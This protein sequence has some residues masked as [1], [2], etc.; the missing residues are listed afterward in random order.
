MSDE[1]NI[2]TPPA[3]YDWKQAPVRSFELRDPEYRIMARS[4]SKGAV[5]LPTLL[6][7][8]QVVEHE[9]VPWLMWADPK[10]VLYAHPD[11]P[12][13]SLVPPEGVHPRECSEAALWDLGLTDHV[14]P[15]AEFEKWV[16]VGRDKAAPYIMEIAGRSQANL[17]KFVLDYCDGQIY[18]DHHVP[19]GTDVGM[20]FMILALGAFSPQEPDEKSG[21]PGEPAWHAAQELPR[22]SPKPESQPKPDPPKR[23]TDPPRPPDAVL[24]TPDPE[25]E[26]RIADRFPGLDGVTDIADLLA[27]AE[28][29]PDAVFQYR[30][31]IERK[32]EERL[33]EHAQ[34]VEAWEKAKAEIASTYADTMAA[35]EAAMT[36]WQEGEASLAT[37]LEQWHRDEE[38]ARAAYAGFQEVRLQNLGV[39]YEHYSKAG[40]RSVNGQPIFFSCCILSRSDWQRAS[41]AIVRELERR[42]NME[43]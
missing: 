33:H 42:E 11:L 18:C 43:I 31:G 10:Y 21:E 35:H 41:A 36:V 2:P 32:N 23:P 28:G 13:V 34:K 12:L 16:Q 30:E 6:G 4:Y 26:G 1:S 17:K 14:L 3:S 19:L 29:I 27:E 5:A 9:G 40:P 38:I 24:L 15:R 20:V 25:E 39:I 7:E 8:P 22:H 37:R